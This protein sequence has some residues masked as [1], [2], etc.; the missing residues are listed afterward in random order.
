[1]TDI[2]L[3][4]LLFSAGVLAAVTLL[5]NRLLALQGSIDRIGEAAAAL[6]RARMA[7]RAAAEADPPTDPGRAPMQTDAG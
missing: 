6:A 2:F 1:M 7:E 4:L 3:I 5:E